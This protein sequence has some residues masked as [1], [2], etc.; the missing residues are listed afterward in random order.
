MNQPGNWSGAI[1]GFIAVSLAVVTIALLW[2][3][4]QEWRR[5]R[6]VAEQIK[7]LSQGTLGS[8]GSSEISLAL[9]RGEDGEDPK[10]LQALVALIPQ[11]RDIAH[12]LEQANMSWSVGTFLLVTLGIGAAFGVSAMIVLPGRL[13]PLLAAAG[14]AALPYAYVRKRRTRRVGEFEKHFPE[15][16][17]LLGRSIRAGHALNSGLEV[18]AEELPD[19]VSTEFRQVFEEQKFGLPLRDSLMAMADRIPLV[20]TRIFVTAVLIQRESGGSLAEILDNI[21]Y[22]IR[23]RFKIRRQL[24][25]HT[26]QGRMTGY[27]L[28]VL[29]IIMGIIMYTMSPEYMSVLFE[30]PMGRF[31][32]GMA[33]VLQVLGYLSIRKIID[34]DI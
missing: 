9:L 21:S 24:K 4:V 12:L 10:W 2:E 25:V 32:L 27:L 34:I 19:P 16:I 11:R 1:F 30:E 6:A 5:R 13:L 29:P 28:A 31:A 20:D 22:T 3:A 33:G 23:E 8:A 15:A 17:D 26:A 7:S 18:I 14:G